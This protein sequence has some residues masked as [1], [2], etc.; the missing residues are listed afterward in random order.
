MRDPV[1]HQ[2]PAPVN[3][4]SE[5]GLTE[6]EAESRLRRDGPN[7]LP[8]RRRRGLAS[9]LREV[10][11]EPMFL[12]LLAGAALYLTLGETGDGVLLL[13]AVIMVIS[14]TLYQTR[15]TDR[16]LEALADL[17]A[18]Q[19]T[20]LRDGLEHRIPGAE[21]VVGDLMILNE[22]ERIAADAVL[23][24]ASH[25]AVDESMLSGESAPVVKRASLEFQLAPSAADATLALHVLYSGTLV[26]AGRGLCEV[27]RTGSH[28][29]LASL[30]HSL[31]GIVT[32]PTRLQQETQRI[33]RALAIAAIF[34]SALVAIVYGMTRGGG[35]FVW[36]EG[37]LAGIAMA[38][39]MLPEEFPVILLVFLALGGWRLS[40]QA[41]L[42]RRVAAIEALGAATVLCVDKTGTLTQNHMTLSRLAT[43]E[44]ELDLSTIET[45][46]AEFAALLQTAQRASHIDAVDPMDRALAEA[47]RRL[48]TDG[49]GEWHPLKEYPLTALRPAVIWLGRSGPI[50]THTALTGC[51]KGAP[52]TI[53]ALCKL[54]PAELADLQRRVSALASRGLRVLAVART[55][56]GQN[57]SS[58]EST[59]EPP[60]LETLPFEFQGLLAFVDPLRAEVPDAVGRFR[61]AGIRVVMITGDYPVT[62]LAIARAAGLERTDTVLTGAELEA[63][64]ESTLLARLR[65][66]DVFA[67]IAP[68]QKLRLIRAF[69]A[70]QEVVAMTGD[71]VNDAPALKAADIGIAMGRRGTD[72]AREAADLV[73]LDDAFSSIVAAVRHGR[74]IYDNICK[75]SVFVLAAHIPIAG[76]S[77][78]PATMAAWPLL[79][80]PVHIVFLEFIIDPACALV[81]EG[82]RDE[83]DLMRRGPRAAASR[84]FSRQVVLT[85]LLQGATMLIA[86]LAI[87]LHF[88]DQGSAAQLRTLTFVTLI[89]ALLTLILVNRSWSESVLGIAGERNVAFVLLVLTSIAGLAAALYWPIATDLFAFAAVPAHALWLAIA[90][91]AA[92]LAWFEGLK[93]FRRRRR[94]SE[95]RAPSST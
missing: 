33:V 35:A 27:I 23:R 85:G 69:K 81:F 28:T 71:G 31:G 11:A 38:M 20:V 37:A 84:L 80:L 88:K 76:L 39:S 67:R 25:L 92:S 89:A 86:C 13:A 1:F 52:E 79:L 51:A 82:E 17:S 93:L 91:G 77:M 4:F 15:R 75:A 34:A 32:E 42:T 49:R 47:A 54:P 7:L 50:D 57:A 29:T 48:G 53:A 43:A 41:V 6:A 73:L 46:P 10:V 94:L 60:P 59:S 70:L 63:M 72:V 58:A 45:L 30:G 44:S 66:T 36:Q 78:I 87:V 65:D 83:V 9:V 16:A 61:E 19:A 22:G 68:Q 62:A 74:R 95:R 56:L 5:S 14:L 55:S 26:T 40:R 64:D 8:T 3:A 12:L 21:L 2:V 24:I 90:A 18:P